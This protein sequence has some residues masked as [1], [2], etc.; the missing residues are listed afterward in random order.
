VGCHFSDEPSP[1]AS[2]VHDDAAGLVAEAEEQI[3][4]WLCEL[5][6]TW[7]RLLADGRGEAAE[8]V[9]AARAEA[10]ALVAAG[11]AE[12]TR[13]VVEAEAR[14]AEI[15][16]RADEETHSL[17]AGAAR[18]ASI[19][20]AEAQIEVQRARAMAAE[21]RATAEA[22]AFAADAAATGRVQIDDLAALG[23][24]VIRLR[25][26]LSRVVDAAFDALPA[27][28]ATAAALQLDDAAHEPAPARK[29]QGFVRRLLRI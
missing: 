24:A 18:L 17:L 4:A 25:S 27:V 11:H 1:Y 28:E 6:A 29:P 12:A 26:E 16:D 20:L 3:E 5:D 15:T 19:Q 21:S 10:T 14:A 9:A 7:T 8:I 13:L 2:D 23:T 22:L